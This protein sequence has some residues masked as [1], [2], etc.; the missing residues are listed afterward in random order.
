MEQCNLKQFGAAIRNN[1]LPIC[2]V[3]FFVVFGIVSGETSL[4]QDCSECG[5]IPC[6]QPTCSNSCSYCQVSANRIVIPNSPHP[7]STYA[8]LRKIANFMS[9]IGLPVAVIF[10]IY[11]GIKFLMARG[12]E[13]KIKEGKRT[14]VW[15]LVGITII[16]GVYVIINTIYK[17]YETRGFQ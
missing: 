6:G 7:T 1:L 3:L 16:L 2:M 4:A 12:N 9:I 15:T 8:V 10:L 11:T 5:I 14:L 17:F 13:E